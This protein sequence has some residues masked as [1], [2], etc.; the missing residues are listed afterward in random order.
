MRPGVCAFQSMAPCSWSIWQLANSDIQKYLRKT[1]LWP[2]LFFAHLG[3][4]Q[5]ASHGLLI[6]E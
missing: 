2:Y 1:N 6:Y 4:G 5:H 3:L